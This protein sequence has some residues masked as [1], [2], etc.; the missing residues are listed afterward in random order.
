MAEVKS[1]LSKQA[2]SQLQSL[3]EPVKLSLLYKASVHGYN[4]AAFHNKCDRQGPTLTVGYNNSGFIFGGYTS[5]SFTQTGQYLA[6][7]KAFIFSWK[8]N[9]PEKQPL[10]IPVVNA[11][12]AILDNNLGPSFGAALV[13]LNGNVAEVITN[14]GQYYTFNAAELHGDDL[15]LTE[16]EV[17]RVEHSRMAEVKSNLS[18]QAES[19]LQSLFE[20]VK[21]S[22]LYKASVHGYNNAAFHNKCDRQGPTLTVG[23]NNSGFIFGG[24]TSM[25]FTQTG[26]YLADEKAF[27]FS[28]KSNDPEKQPLRIPVVNAQYAILD[29][30]L[31][32]SFGAAL[33]FLN[34]NVAEVITNP[35]QYYTFNAAELHGDDLNLTECEVYRVELRVLLVGPVGAGKSSFFNSVNSVFRGHVTNQAPAGSS[36]TS[37][38]TKFNPSMAIQEDTPGFIKS[39]EMKDRI[40]CVAFVM[41]AC[42]V[43]IMSAKLEEKFSAIR[44]KVNFIGVPQLV[45]LTKVDEACELVASD[46]SSVY[47]SRFIEGKM[48][49]VGARLGIPVSCIVPVRNYSTE[50]ELDCNTDILLLSAIVQML[51]FADNY[52]DDISYDEKCD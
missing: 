9:D 7:E 2:E 12:Y 52:F 34:G 37:L 39:A 17:Y 16:C 50:L 19:Q 22:L 8:S 24:Y 28:W 38:T 6:D 41:D 14:P 29:N 36:A 3:F 13:F 32:P 46:V 42:K 27:I 45:L 5:M 35:G 49:E 31:G 48:Q 20:P 30:N 18:K 43:K 15:N 4:N 40:H 21:L 51:R 23:Y 11:Q 10:R 25:S 26:Q 44:K 33:V 1:N 47:K